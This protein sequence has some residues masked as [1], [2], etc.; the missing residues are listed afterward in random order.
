MTITSSEGV[1]PDPRID[2]QF[3]D[4]ICADD[5]LMQAEFEAI[6]AAEWA[7]SPPVPRTGSG[8]ADGRSVGRDH[9]RPAP[10]LGSGENRPERVSREIPFARSP[11]DAQ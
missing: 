6:V 11:P 5:A 2:E 3:I 9:R 8:A 4:I 1:R 7:M 10:R